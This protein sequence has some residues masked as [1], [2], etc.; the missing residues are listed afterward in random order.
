MGH[1]RETT[2]FPDRAILG[3]KWYDGT[4]VRLLLLSPYLWHTFTHTPRFSSSQLCHFSHTPLSTIFQLTVSHSFPRTQALTLTDTLQ[5]L[6]ACKMLY[7]LHIT[8]RSHLNT[9]MLMS[10]SW[11]KA[12]S[13]VYNFT[14][15]IPIKCPTHTHQS[16]SLLLSL[17]A[18]HPLFRCFRA[19][20]ARE[21][22]ACMCKR[23]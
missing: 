23:G 9:W 5:L 16:T 8:Y 20:N 11:L 3:M 21:A 1:R 18:S 19:G 22:R 10:V 15:S 14:P 4:W 7:H 6:D 17:C 13:D 12:K 2:G